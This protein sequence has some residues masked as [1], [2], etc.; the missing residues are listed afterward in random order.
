MSKLTPIQIERRKEYSR[1]ISKELKESKLRFK[2]LP[3]ED[4]Q[5]FKK[6]YLSKLRDKYKNLPEEE[7][8]L[9]RLR[10]NL[11]NTGKHQDYNRIKKY[12]YKKKYNS[13]EEELKNILILQN[14]RCP[15]CFSMLDS[16]SSRKS[17]ID[18]NHTTGKVR[19]ILCHK[20]NVGLGM[21]KEDIT[22]LYNAINYL[23]RH[24]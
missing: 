5:Q 16:F 10:T 18:H 4:K 21:F 2:D 9:R 14:N 24:K 17:H 6:E 1:Q 23:E 8:F 15:I 13:N 11:H 7:L 19:A 22:L 20:C 12:N 3:E